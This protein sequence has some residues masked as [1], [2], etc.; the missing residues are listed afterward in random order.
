MPLTFNIVKIHLKSVI[1]NPGDLCM[2]LDIKDFYYGVPL[3]E[4][5]YGNLPLDF[6]PKEII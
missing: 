1:S 6:L 4:H 5:E 2:P 3:E